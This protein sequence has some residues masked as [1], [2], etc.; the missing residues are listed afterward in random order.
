MLAKNRIG[1]TF[2][3]PYFIYAII[4]FLIPLA[5]AIWLSTMDWNL[6]SITR[7]WVGLQNF[8]AA[9]TSEK[10]QAAFINSLKY[11]AALIPSVMVISTI[12]A[13]LLHHLPPRI[14]GI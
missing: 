1:W 14:K 11:M 3:A 5:W 7:D 6:M 10:I 4:F 12:I 8:I 13:L 2:S 9:F